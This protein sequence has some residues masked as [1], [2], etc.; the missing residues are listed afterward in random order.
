MTDKK[1]LKYDL[2]KKGLFP[3]FDK[4]VLEH[5]DTNDGSILDIEKDLKLLLNETKLKLKYLE[6]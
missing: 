6:K 1:V 4:I 2:Y 3:E 5:F